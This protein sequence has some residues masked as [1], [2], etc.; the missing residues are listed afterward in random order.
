[1]SFPIFFQNKPIFV[2]KQSAKFPDNL[3]RLT[4]L[5]RIAGFKYPDRDAF[6]EL[7]RLSGFQKEFLRTIELQLPPSWRKKSINFLTA[8]GAF[9]Y[10]LLMAPDKFWEFF[11]WVTG[12]N[13]VAPRPNIYAYVNQKKT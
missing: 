13:P 11:Q 12:F 4:D 1:M 3:Y 10:M 5:A 6:V 8:T 9:A 7:K 2:I